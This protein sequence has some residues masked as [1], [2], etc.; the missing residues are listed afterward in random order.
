MAGFT[1][2]KSRLKREK[3]KPKKDIKE[4]RKL[5]REKKERQ[6]VGLD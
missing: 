2:D 3:K 5:K 4:R 1:G 6:K